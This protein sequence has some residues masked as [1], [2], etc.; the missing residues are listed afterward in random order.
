M[1]LSRFPR[2]L[3]LAL[4]I[5]AILGCGGG[6]LV[7]PPDGGPAEG[8]GG[9]G[10]S[11]SR[12]TISADPTSIPAG[13]GSSTITVMVRNGD[14]D[15]VT[16]ASVVLE[17]NGSDNTLTQPSGTTGSD[18]TVTGTVSSAVPGTILISA[19]INGS[20]D[21]SQPAQ[22]SVTPASARIELIEGDN[23][24]AP[25]GSPVPIQPAVRIVDG[26]GQPVSGVEV[27]FVVT[28]GGGSVDSGVQ[29]TNADGIARTGWTLG[30]SPGRN[31]LEA[32]AGG[33]PDSPVIFSAD[34][35]AGG[36]DHFV[37]RV[38]PQDVRV[39]ERFSVEVAMVD[40]DGDVV[41]LSGI[42]IYLGLFPEAQDVPSNDR[43][44]GDRFREAENGVAVFSRLGVTRE[45]R[46]R[47][48]ALSDQLPALGPHGPEPYLFSQPF[49]VR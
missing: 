29:S 12:S 48:R 6:D 31:T 5:L 26:Q 10:P 14:G 30:S 43:L 49:Q 33:L 38:Q 17:A 44:R 23:Q 2:G 24:R 3:F 32:R 15:P 35:T 45:G 19:T 11:A 25:V 16:G 18:G 37:F 46:Y 1:V 34:G 13:A 22:V 7:L 8:G 47:F 39:D 36:V 20:V 21:V 28:G 42:E 9:T 27:A 40:A 4:P 41:P